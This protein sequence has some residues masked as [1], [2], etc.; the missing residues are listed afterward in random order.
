MFTWNSQ[1]FIIIVDYYSRYFE[2]EKFTSCT[3]S[4]VI[5]KCKAS[6]ARHGIPDTVVS[7]NGLCYSSI[8]F[9]LFADKWDFKHVTSCYPQSNGLA[10]RTVQTAKYI[11]D[12][13]K[14]GMKDHHLSLLEH[15][16]TLVDNL[17]SPAQLLMSRRLCS[18]LPVTAR[19]LKP[20]AEDS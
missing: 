16:N 12:K 1:D 9:R 3:S 4:A 19:Q 17:K 8:E 5:T 11:L 13:A 6:F 10:E 15:R 2:M 20:E 18:V 14:A 7:N